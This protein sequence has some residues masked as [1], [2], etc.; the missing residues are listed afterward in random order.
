MSEKRPITYI[1]EGPKY[2]L[3]LHR[4]VTKQNDLWDITLP[5]IFVET[6]EIIP[7]YRWNKSLLHIYGIWSL[8]T[9]F[10]NEDTSR[11][12]SHI[13]FRHI[14][15]HSISPRSRNILLFRRL[16][17]KRLNNQEILLIMIKLR[18]NILSK[19][20]FFKKRSFS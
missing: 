13:S 6:H 9:L 11:V 10:F 15:F 3:E 16:V 20:N 12:C 8:K 4:Y 14:L 17:F 5:I 7:V 18:L 1:W 2:A 19:Y